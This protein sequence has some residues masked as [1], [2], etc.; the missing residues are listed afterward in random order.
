MNEQIEPAEH[1]QWAPIP[2]GV[3]P[4]EIREQFASAFAS[5]SYD[6]DASA[7]AMA[8]VAAQLQAP[9]SD[10]AVN[11]AA[12]ARVGTPNELDV[13]GFATLRVVPLEADASHDDV[14]ALLLEGQELFQEP[15]TTTIGTQSGD[16]VSVQL[17]PLVHTADGQVEVHQVSAV[18]WSRPTHQALFML[19]SYDVDLVQA[20]DTA[21]LL[22]E[23]AVGIAG[24]SA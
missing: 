11:L 9:T 4:E 19:S 18:L 15:A 21:V 24:M 10:G 13:R 5:S 1:A 23:L 22:D 2:L 20:T 12:W 7:A 17:R 16:A 8:G 14:M 3:D 6:A